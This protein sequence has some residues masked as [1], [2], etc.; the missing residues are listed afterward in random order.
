M[1]I[2]LGIIFLVVSNDEEIRTELLGVLNATLCAHIY[3][4]YLISN[5][6]YDLVLKTDMTYK[7]FETLPEWR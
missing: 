6:M 7:D 5:P 1:Y 3:E 4:F 2:K